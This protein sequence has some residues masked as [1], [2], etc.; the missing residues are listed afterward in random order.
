MQVMQEDGDPHHIHTTFW[1]F[2]LLLALVPILVPLLVCGGLRLMNY[3][4][5]WEE[6]KHK[7]PSPKNGEDE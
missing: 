4:D 6:K 3:L 5:R 7:R 2:Y 1:G